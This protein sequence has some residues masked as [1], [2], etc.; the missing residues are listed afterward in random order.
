MNTESPEIS[1]RLIPSQPP[2]PKGFFSSLIGYCVDNPF[3]VILLAALVG[4]AGWISVK[5]I[6]LD[7]IPDL[8]DNQVIVLAEWNGRGPRVVDD[9]VAYPLSTALSACIAYNVETA[10]ELGCS[11]LY[12]GEAPGDF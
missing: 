11:R 6:K 3:I 10:P 8:S 1:G 7:A 2:V 4:Y 12:H 5:S 9:Q